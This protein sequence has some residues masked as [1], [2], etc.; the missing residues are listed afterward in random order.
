MLQSKAVVSPTN[1]DVTDSDCSDGDQLSHD[2]HRKYRSIV[3]NLLYI[4]IKSRSKLAFVASRLGLYVSKSSENHTMQS[5]RV[6]IYVKSSKHYML[7][8]TPRVS[9]QL[10]AYVNFSWESPTEKNR[11]TWTGK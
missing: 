7:T 3:K 11:R 9:Y 2:S 8:M 5:Q 1:F 4:E 6:L 10:S